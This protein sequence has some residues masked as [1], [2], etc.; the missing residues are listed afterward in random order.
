MEI[1]RAKQHNDSIFKEISKN[2]NFTFPKG[3]PEVENTLNDW[4]HW[5]QFQNELEQKPKTS[6]LAFKNKIENVSKKADS[7]S[8]TV[9]ERF[10]NPQVRSRLITLN[11]Q[12]NSLDTY[13]HLNNNI[14]KAKVI[15][16]IKSVNEE[17]RGVYNQMEEVLI[18]ER[19]PMEIGEEAMIRA[20]DTTRLA[21]S[22]SFEENLI[23]T[24]S[25]QAPQRKPIKGF[26]KK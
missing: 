4:N 2:W 24:D 5:H 20:L 13:M 7:L 12:L 1:E 8:V 3:S 9:P 14:P 19:I 22:K 21:N 16:L 17:I 23:K 18:K 6:M 25:V 10:N 11:T 15:A 26:P